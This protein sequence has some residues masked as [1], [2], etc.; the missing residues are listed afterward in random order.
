MTDPSELPP[1]DLLDSA[2]RMRRLVLA[3]LVGAAAATAAYFICES[4]AGRDMTG[5]LVYGFGHRQRAYQFVYYVT[6]LA[7]AVCFLVALVLQNKLA[8]RKYR[9][10]LVPRARVERE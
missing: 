10:G 5:D 1:P 6:G 8:D 4:L 7:G 9:A 3:L 2:G